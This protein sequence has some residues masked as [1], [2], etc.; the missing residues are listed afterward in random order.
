MIEF[1]QNYIGPLMKKYGNML[2]ATDCPNDAVEN[3]IRTI[4]VRLLSGQTAVHSDMIM[5]NP[6]EPVERAA[7]QFI[8]ILFSVPQISVRLDQIPEE[9]VQMSSFW[10]SFWREHRDVLL[11]GKLSPGRPDF[12]YSIIRAKAG[13]KQIVCVY[14]DIVVNIGNTLPETLII[15][16]G[17]LQSRLVLEFAQ[18]LGQVE[19][20]TRNCLGQVID[21]R[22]DSLQAGLQR[23]DIPASGIVTIKRKGEVI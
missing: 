12:L 11:E 9:H 7:L 14:E 16:N 6:N 2:R 23:L 21:D 3:R 18:D 1:R 22:D 5:W 4:D 15:V 8:N 13:Q 10:L 20:E 17:T 19:M